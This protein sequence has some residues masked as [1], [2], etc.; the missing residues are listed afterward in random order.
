MKIIF[1]SCHGNPVFEEAYDF[2]LRVMDLK[3]KIL[4]ASQEAGA[5]VKYDQ[6]QVQQMTV[7][8]IGTGIQD[9]LVQQEMRSSLSTITTDED[10]LEI[11]TLTVAAD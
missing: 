3:Q 9:P 8:A 5:A 1:L 10:I 11:L 2:V 4:F 7:R 6:A